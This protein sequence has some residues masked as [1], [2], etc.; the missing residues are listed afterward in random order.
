[1]KETIKQLWPEMVKNADEGKCPWC[2]N[3][4]ALVPFRDA[5]SIKE[6]EISG[7]CQQCQDEFFC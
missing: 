1:M 3:M 2:G 6:F 7:L 5:L 4:I